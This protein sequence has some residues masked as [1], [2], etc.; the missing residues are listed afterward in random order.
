MT[1]YDEW[2]YHNTLADI[3]DFMIMLGEERVLLDISDRYNG[4]EDTMKPPM[5]ISE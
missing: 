3:V 5:E 2:H 4:I 1:E